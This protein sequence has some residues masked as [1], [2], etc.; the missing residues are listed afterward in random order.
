[1]NARETGK[2]NTKLRYIF[3]RA[4]GF[5]VFFGMDV[6]GWR[7]RET[8]KKRFG[9]CIFWARA[10]LQHALIK[11][12]KVSSNAFPPPPA[13][14]K[15]NQPLRISTHFPIYRDSSRTVSSFLSSNYAGF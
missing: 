10:A 12:Q 1:M 14:H 15:V 4:T 11:T 5:W 3:S 6:Y 9:L 8:K 13:P 2:H 7:A